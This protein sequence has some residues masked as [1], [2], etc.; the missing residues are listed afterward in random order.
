MTTTVGKQKRKPKSAARIDEG[1]EDLQGFDDGNP[2]VYRRRLQRWARRR[3]RA[4][5]RANGQLPDDNDEP[6]DEFSDPANTFELDLKEAHMPHPTIPDTVLEDGYKVPGDIY[7]ALFDYQKT[8]VQWL[9][10]LYLQQ[11]GGIIGDE[12][13]LG[14]TIQIIAFLAGM[15]Y[16]KKLDKP[17]I[18]VCPATV[19]KQW[20]NEFH[21]WWPALRVTILHSS[22]SGMINVHSESS[23][24]DRMEDEIWDPNHRNQPLTSAQKTAKKIVQP[25][26][27]HGGVL[28]TT[29]SGLQSYAPLLIPVDWSYAILDEGHKIRNPNTAI[30]IYSKELR[31]PKIGRAHV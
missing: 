27:Q 26:L 10:E 4:R 25:V 1:M 22:G 7:P 12:M 29:Y 15:H 18:V 23:R 19:M 14:K 6:D 16:S 31:T 30:T 9:H 11:V 20:V 3:R 8:G 17:A 21:T 5:E 2:T 24:E 28:V 13:G